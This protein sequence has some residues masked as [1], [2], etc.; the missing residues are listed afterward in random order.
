VFMRALLDTFDCQ[1]WRLA[2]VRLLRIAKCRAV[3]WET[4]VP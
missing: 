2:S 4:A 3:T 1:W